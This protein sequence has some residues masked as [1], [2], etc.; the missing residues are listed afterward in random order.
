MSKEVRVSA[1]LPDGSL[2]ASWS[3]QEDGTHIPGYSR[4]D[5]QRANAYLVEVMDQLE[6]AMKKH[7]PFPTDKHGFAVIWEE[8]DELWDEV[9]SQEGARS[10]EAVKE[11]LQIACC[12][13][14]FIVDLIPREMDEKIA[15]HL[16]P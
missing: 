10:P 9:K 14:R 8:V 12:C 11:L 4:A 2:L 15:R 16:H 6:K 1:T 13:I 5:H 7:K 3:T